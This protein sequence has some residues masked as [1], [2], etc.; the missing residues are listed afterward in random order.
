MN[1]P[2]D[3]VTGFHYLPLEDLVPSSTQ[4]QAARRRRFND[5]A[6]DELAA[7]I[8]QSGVLQPILARRSTEWAS[9]D[10]LQRAEKYEIVAGERRFLASQR[11]GLAQ[12]PAIVRDISDAEVL[13][14]Q[15]V[16]NIQREDLDPLSE[17][18][19]Y[20]ELMT[21]KSITADQLGEIVGKS[22]SAIFARLK[23]L[24]LS[25]A[26]RE[27]VEQ[28]KL[29]ASRAL[30]VARIPDEKHQA[31]ALKLA[32]EQDW[33]GNPRYSY[34]DLLEEFGKKGT[35]V[36]LAGVPWKLT[37]DSLL[38]G[39]A[40]ACMLCPHMTGNAMSEIP[41]DSADVCTRPVCFR[42]KQKAFTKR[43]AQKAADNGIVIIKGDEA[44]KIAPRNDW[45]VG[46]IDLDHVC[47]D[48]EYPEPEPPFADTPE[49]QTAHAAWSIK[50]E[51]WKSRTYRELIG[52]AGCRVILLEDPK[53]KLIRELVPLADAKKGLEAVGITLADWNVHKD[54]PPLQLS[55]ADHKARREADEK[56]QKEEEQ[57][58]RLVFEAVYPK[59]LGK[60]THEEIVAIALDRSQDWDVKRLLEPIYG[61]KYQSIGSWP[62]EEIGRLLRIATFANEIT[63]AYGKPEDL[64]AIAKKHK[65]DVAAIRKS[66]NEE[67]PAKKAATKKATP[68]KKATA[69]PV[70]KK[71]AT[72][73]A[74]AK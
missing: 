69:K 46:Y 10:S 56:K 74:K 20:R 55:P 24:Q 70:A 5:T 2:T 11:A 30:L 66:M 59:L 72:K 44:K 57:F 50:F 9:V 58:R 65:V 34:R 19:G 28:G 73:K 48:D 68:S 62:A 61:A 49:Y 51:E 25:P 14:A 63:S 21:L 67:A 42:N 47:E 39:D 6:L 26:G 60:P 36:S 45:L 17:A 1:A 12:I 7:S 8:K 29:D 71:T 27:A 4:V 22:R 35:T 38:P 31:M 53:T 64:L 3:I 43:V 18:E 15:L 16:E 13:E 54:A 33:R 41:S 37:D 40:P 32:L 23:L 52:S